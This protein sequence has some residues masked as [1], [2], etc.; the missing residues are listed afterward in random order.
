MR[1]NQPLPASISDALR[2]FD[3]LPDSANVRRPVVRALFGW[4]DTTLHRRIQDGT[5]PAPSKM[6]PRI[7][8]WNVGKIRAVL[9]RNDS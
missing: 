7:A 6:S 3:Q 1:K 2:Q 9:S 4:S 8:T 5:L